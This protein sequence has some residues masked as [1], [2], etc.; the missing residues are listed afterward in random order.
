MLCYRNMIKH[1]VIQKVQLNYH[2]I[3]SERQFVKDI[4]VICKRHIPGHTH[5]IDHGTLSLRECSYYIIHTML[6]EALNKLQPNG[7]WLEMSNK[8]CCLKP[9][10][11]NG[12]LMRFI[13]CLIQSECKLHE[14]MLFYICILNKLGH[15][16]DI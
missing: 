12:L 1:Y 16:V 11:L 4:L 10:S 7:R 3:E 6:C 8:S 2:Y 5:I 14:G 9:L 13:L 15:N